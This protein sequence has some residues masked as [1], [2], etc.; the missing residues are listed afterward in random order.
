MHTTMY[1]CTLWETLLNC[2]FMKHLS[3]LQ[4]V[5]A[6]TW[7][8][9]DGRPVRVTYWGEGYPHVYEQNECVMHKDGQFEA[10]WVQ[11]NCNEKRAFVCKIST[12]KFYL[13]I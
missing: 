4:S 2:I 9:V 6:R 8:W 10:E 13:R 7:S 11:A 3:F 5:G 1:E 12:C